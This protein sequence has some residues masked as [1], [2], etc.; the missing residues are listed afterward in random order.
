MGAGVRVLR[1]EHTNHAIL[2]LRV[3]GIGCDEVEHVLRNPQRVY[4][5]VVTHTMIAIGPRIRR[6]NHWLV[7][8]YTRVGDVYRVV[9]VIDTKSLDKLVDRRERSGRW[10]RVW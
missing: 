5:D 4:Y 2:R 6:S 1:I 10:V 3:R 8:V 9:T 7:V